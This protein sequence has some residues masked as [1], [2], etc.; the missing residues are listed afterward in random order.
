MTNK[1]RVDKLGNGVEEDVFAMSSGERIGW[2]DHQFLLLLPEATYNAV[3]RFLAGRRQKIA[4]TARSLWKNLE[5]RNVISV[6]RGADGRVQRCPKC[7]I[8]AKALEKNGK[9][10]RPRL[11]RVYKHILEDAASE[12]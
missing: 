4:V 2:Y 1:V 12:E 9:N 3:D 10:Y 8:P 6:E 7:T 5:E 11:L